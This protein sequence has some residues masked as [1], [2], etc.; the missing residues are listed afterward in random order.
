M[1]LAHLLAIAVAAFCAGA[2][3][4]IV[5]S[6]SLLTFPT[7]LALGYSPLVANVSNTVGL[8]FGSLSGVWGYREQLRGQTGRI[9]SLGPIAALGAAVGAMLLLALPPRAFQTIV[10]VL[11]LI[12]VA[13]VV[14]QPHLSRRRRARELGGVPEWPK[15][16]DCKSDG[17]S[18]RRFESF[19]HHATEH[20]RGL[21][22][23]ERSSRE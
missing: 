10:P 1:S 4:T 21:D 23:P 22:S 12:A 15:G 19:P 13:L 17:A 7:L 20:E 8:A 2:I 16:S 14:A 3:N 11:I 5:G 18:L 6:G 9:R